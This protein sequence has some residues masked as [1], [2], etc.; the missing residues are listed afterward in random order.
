MTVDRN[1]IFR[2]STTASWMPGVANE[3]CQAAVENWC[4]VEIEATRRVS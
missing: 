4:Q 1:A 2:D 3:C